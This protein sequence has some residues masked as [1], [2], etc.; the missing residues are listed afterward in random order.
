MTR[1]G[2]LAVVAL[3][4]GLAACKDEPTPDIPDPTPSSTSPSVSESASPT[5]PTETPEVLTPEETVR[6]WVAARN[7]ALRDGETSGV[8]A[9]TDPS[10]SSCVDLITSIEEVYAAGGRFETKGWTVKAAA[11]KRP[12]GSRPQIDVAMVIAGGQTVN[13]AGAEPVVYEQDK[14]IVVFKVH[15]VENGFLVDFVGFLS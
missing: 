4:C 12:N 7:Q 9:L 1:R 13:E 3:L 2:A 10:C 6:A 8:R 11:T 5:T 15:P 14:R